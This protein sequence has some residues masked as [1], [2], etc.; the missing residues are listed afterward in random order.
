MRRN[1]LVVLL[2]L[3]T[4]CTAFAS[5]GGEKAETSEKAN[6]FAIILQ[7]GG[8]GDEGWNDASWAGFQTMAKKYNLN[9]DYFKA[10]NAAD[11]EIFLREIAET[12]YG[13]IFCL[14]TGLIMQCVGIA[15]DYPNTTFVYPAKLNLIANKGN[16]IWMW[17]QLNELGFMA[18]VIAS[19]LATDGNQIIDGVACQSGVKV[20]CIFAADS[21]GF[22]RYA[23]GFAH[24][25]KWYNPDCEIVYDFTAGY[26]DTAYCQT[27]AE[28]MIKNG[29]D[30]IWTCCGTAGLGGLQ[31]CRLNNAL[32]IGVDFNQDS[33]EPGSV[34]TSV[35]RNMD[36]NV[37]W[38]V[39]SWL[40][41]TIQG[42]QPEFN[43]GNGGL[44]ITD[45]SVIEQY[46]TN[47]ENFK[48]LK[49]LIADVE[50]QI[51]DETLRPFD[52][53]ETA[54][55]GKELVRFETWWAENKDTNKNNIHDWFYRDNIVY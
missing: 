44:G 4:L 34:V 27:I 2:L 38:M 22:Y 30:V 43:I 50:K 53:A 42:S 13:V 26:T 1:F 39:E 55:T 33:K 35:M 41:G 24:G 48:A 20:G 37:E 45:L 6:A 15:A 36:K 5:G 49:A 51:A 47:K 31:A 19:Y 29:C 17:Y 16:E 10:A 52:T 40:N 18:G 46:V 23:D 25:A 11:T 21:Q 28:N 14:D 8:L 12:G 32:G 9:G 3:V 7:S 54:Y